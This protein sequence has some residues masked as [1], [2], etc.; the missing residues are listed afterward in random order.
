MAQSE[1]RVKSAIPQKSQGQKPGAD[2]STP[3]APTAGTIK[4]RI[5]SEDGR[6]LTNA[7]IVAQAVTGGP[8]GKMT[9]VDNEGRFVFSDL[10]LALYLIRAT[11][12]GYVDQSPSLGD[13]SQW[14]R[15]LIGAQLKI[16]MIKGGVITGTVTN[17]KGD[18]VV[19]VPVGVSPMDVP[20]TSIANL[21]GGGAAE[22]DDRGVYRI[23]GLVQGQYT[24]SAGGS[25]SLGRLTTNGFD[26]DVPTYYPS[27]T[28]D[29]AIPVVVR[30]AEE[31]TGID[32]K[33]KGTEGHS[34][35]GT[36]SGTVEANVASGVISIMLSHAGTTSV[37]SV[38]IASAVDQRRVFSFN[39]IADGEYDLFV[40]SLSGPDD[41]SSIAAKRVIVRGGDVTG[42]DLSLAP[43]ASIAGTIK[44]DPIR[45]EDK[46]DKRGSQPIE[47][48]I[49]VR[50]ADQ[51]KTTGHMMTS[52][53]AGLSGTLNAKGEFI[54]RN[55]EP[56]RYR[57]EIKVPT[58]AWYVR[59][60]NLPA[61]ASQRGL[62]PSATNPNQRDAW[63][64]VM[65]IKAGEKVSGVSIMV[66]QDAA[67]L[68]GVLAAAPQGMAISAGAQV[69]LIPAEPGQANNVLRYSETR[70]NSDGSFAFSRVAPGRYFIFLRVESPTEKELTLPRPS[71]WEPNARAKLRREA[72][73]ANMIVELKP[74]Q[75]LLDY[76]L[77]LKADQ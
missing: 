25:G 8:A 28:R 1:P 30:N 23:Y 37:L 21:M 45:A 63:P 55:L 49:N 67:V 19:G 43:L 44:L 7:T 42:L 26:L 5:V 57:F 17:S 18:P 74:C 66:A 9:R 61:A 20:P 69:R 15:H 72:E 38:A 39:G 47:T 33:Y 53:F 56:A 54:V 65:A 71:A 6:P 70:V 31:T 58:D 14:P 2:E 50:R 36:V 11:A 75:R 34:I 52:L 24:V 32:I 73:A 77:P 22:T 60:I 40:L 4:G 68:Q 76:K 35:S 41:N 64:D 3:A 10:P 48:F 16:T 12:P 27:S 59:A 29:S 51:K 62:Q 46:C 13:P